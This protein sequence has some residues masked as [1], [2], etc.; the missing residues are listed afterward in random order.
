MAAES[1]GENMAKVKN[2]RWKLFKIWAK[3]NN[4]SGIAVNVGIVLAATILIE[5]YGLDCYRETEEGLFFEFG[6][7]NRASLVEWLLGFGGKVKVLEPEYI[8]QDLKSA[9]ETILSRYSQT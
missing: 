1:V 5:I 3:E 9:A 8:A 7:T 6:F 2:L 4:L